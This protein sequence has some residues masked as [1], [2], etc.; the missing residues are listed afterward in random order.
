MTCIKKRERKHIE[1]SP[2]FSFSED[3]EIG[4]TNTNLKEY[5]FLKQQKN[6]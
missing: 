3:K 6:H 2:Q 5:S 4:N 1:T